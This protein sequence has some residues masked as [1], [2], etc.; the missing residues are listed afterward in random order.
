MGEARVTDTV[1]A[2]S[3]SRWR[4]IFG[5]RPSPGPVLGD[6]AVRGYVQVALDLLAR[7]EELHER[8]LVALDEQRRTERLA[9]AAAVYRWQLNAVLARFEALPVPS[10]LRAWH[11][12]LLEALGAASR[13]THLLSHGYRFHV[14][15]IICDGGLLLEEAREQEQAARDALQSAGS[16]SVG[17]A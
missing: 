10:A 5:R 16:L 17:A 9:N 12:A 11:D 7:W 4:S 6:E 1:G 3:G 8:W 15:R 14:V 2:A 13:G